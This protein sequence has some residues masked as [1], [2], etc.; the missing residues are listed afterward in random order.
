MWLLNYT[1]SEGVRTEV[2]KAG[3]FK[4]PPTI[5]TPR[6]KRAS[7]RLS[8]N[9]QAGSQAES[10]NGF[11]VPMKVPSPK[12]TK[13]PGDS[14]PNFKVPPVLPTHAGPVRIT[15]ST[16]SFKKPESLLTDD[17][18]GNGGII[19]V[20]EPTRATFDPPNLHSAIPSSSMTASS[21]RSTSNDRASPLSS[22]ISSPPSSPELDASFQE[23]SLLTFKPPVSRHVTIINKCPYCKDRVD[24][25]FLLDFDSTVRLSVR[26][27]S[28]FCKA[29][30][31]RSA[32]VEWKEK[33]YPI[34]DWP[35]FDKRLNKFHGH[36]ND[37]ME[38][39]RDSFYRNAYEER[40][41]S[42]QNET[43]KQSM[44]TGDGLENLEL[45]YYGSRGA[46]HM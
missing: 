11:K 29:H 21:R 31:I 34:I 14:M 37:I 7:Q 9:G 45:G 28:R 18:R 16:Q 42:R 33:G 1:A 15:R 46:K 23:I 5:G 27:Q 30:R 43:A 22:S 25:D 32:E 20:V 39:Q 26:E 19:N 4:V 6:A 12:K 35:R 44:M 2:S 41:K 24:R 38:N 17:L 3:A 8:R 10:T 40:F 13:Q 36:L